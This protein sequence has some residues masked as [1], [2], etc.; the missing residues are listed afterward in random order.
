MRKLPCE[1][2]A[3]R[4]AA[5]QAEN[6]SQGQAVANAKECSV[7]NRA[8]QSPQR[9]VFSTQ[10]IIGEIQGP[11]TS[12]E[13]PKILINAS[14]CLSIVRGKVMQASRIG[15]C[16]ARNESLGP[17]ALSCFLGVSIPS[18]PS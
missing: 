1:G 18:S 9:P 6:G 16:P 3:M 5:H 11:S 2:D 8:R 15:H 4:C 14:V 12:N 10:K 7:D 13:L 17:Y